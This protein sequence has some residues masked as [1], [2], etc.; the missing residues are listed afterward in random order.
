M[1]I[2]QT[3]L[4]QDGSQLT[5]RGRRCLQDYQVR[6]CHFRGNEK[7][8]HGWWET[9]KLTAPR[10]YFTSEALRGVAGRDVHHKRRVAMLLDWE[11]GP[12]AG[13]PAMQEELMAALSLALGHL[14]LSRP[15]G[16]SGVVSKWLRLSQT[17]TPALQGTG[18]LWLG[19]E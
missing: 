9:F 15:G 5:R 3:S 13:S 2:L 4:G 17:L 6:S 19:F 14:K 10:Q 16:S 1:K 8:R 12:L 18:W 11:E 7:C